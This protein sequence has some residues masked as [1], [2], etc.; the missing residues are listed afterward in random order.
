MKDEWKSHPPTTLRTLVLGLGNPIL[1]DDAAGPKVAALVRERLA[2]EKIIA[3][4]RGLGDESQEEI[5]SSP[6]PGHSCT[7]SEETCGGLRLMERLAGYDRA[8]LVDAIRTGRYS[9]GTIL[10]LTLDDIPTQNSASVHDVNLPTALRLAKTVGLQMPS[11]IRIIAIEAEN[12]LEFSEECTPA[13]AAALPQ[14]AAQVLLELD[15]EW[16]ADDADTRGFMRI[17]SRQSVSV[18]AGLLTEPGV[19]R[20][21]TGPSQRG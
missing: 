7:V 11:D 16:N 2:A 1:G 15:Q 4:I 3:G 14:A 21:E 5:P 18:Q 19:A 17:R 6:H 13:V 9:P 20:S 8:I 12:T 10:K